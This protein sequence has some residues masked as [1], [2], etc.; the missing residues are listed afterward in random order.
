MDL[1]ICAL[2]IETMTQDRECC[3]T[4]LSG[5]KRYCARITIERDCSSAHVIGKKQCT[6][7]C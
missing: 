7:F 2:L 5:V 4:S 6:R 3:A 1:G